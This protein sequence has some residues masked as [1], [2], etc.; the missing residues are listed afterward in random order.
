[1]R[2]I[3]ALLIAVCALFALSS[4]GHR[5]TVDEWQVDYIGH[6]HICTECEERT[7][8][9]GHEFDS[10][11]ICI[12]CGASVTLNSNGNS[13]VTVYDTEGNVVREVVFDKDGNL[14]N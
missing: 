5:H 3:I 11:N 8:H 9:T 2:K 6:W 13:V 14:I 10:N 1:M 7:D 4:C 12:V